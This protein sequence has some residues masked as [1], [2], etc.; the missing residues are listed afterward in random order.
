MLYLLKYASFLSV[1]LLLHLIW[2]ACMTAWLENNI[3]HLFEFTI[4]NPCFTTLYCNKNNW[5]GITMYLS[6]WQNL[7]YY[8]LVLYHVI[9]FGQTFINDV[10]SPN[11]KLKTDRL[12][13]NEEYC[14]MIWALSFLYLC[15]EISIP[16]IWVNHR[17]KLCHMSFS[18]SISPDTKTEKYIW[19]YIITSDISAKRSLHF[20]WSRIMSF[21]PL[22]INLGW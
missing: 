17:H 2:Y 22:P 12:V 20:C 16:W 13:M 1:A 21:S 8:A 10:Q 14:N 6:W 3:P 7:V 19:Y 11:D 9:S 18:H 15:K 4:I 5:C